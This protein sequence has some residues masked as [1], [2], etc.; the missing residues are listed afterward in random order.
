[1]LLRGMDGVI[2]PYPNPGFAKAVGATMAHKA[3]RVE[4]NF[5]VRFGI[6]RRLKGKVY[7]GEFDCASN[8]CDPKK[9]ATLSSVFGLNYRA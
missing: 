6:V 4:V 7:M 5:M 9:S 1:M 3:K 2:P 8:I